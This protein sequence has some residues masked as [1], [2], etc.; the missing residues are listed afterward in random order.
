MTDNT[1]ILKKVKALITKAES[2]DSPAEAETFFTKAQEL[3]VRHRISQADL[4]TLDPDIIQQDEVAAFK[5]RL[6]GEW[7]TIL[8][9]VI[10]R[11][12]GCEYVRCKDI[13]KFKI[14]GEKHDIAL[15][16]YLFETT[17]DTFRR[18]SKSQWRNAETHTK[19]NQYIRSFLVGAC[20]GLAQQIK[21]MTAEVVQETGATTYALMLTNK[22]VKAREHIL[23]QGG[24]KQ[25]KT[26]T[27]PG[28]VEGYVQGVI[29]GS[30]HKLHRPVGGQHGSMKSLN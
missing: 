20:D 11:T 2:T 6:E 19:K 29:A 15:V 7:E 27:T 10:F 14:Y 13:A 17:R 30:R 12:N 4:N 23:A 3:M 9:R 25:T 26:H 18:L 5:N 21:R 1:E 22:V 8:A 28:S 24:V 16:K